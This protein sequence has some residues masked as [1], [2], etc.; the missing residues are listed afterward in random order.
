MSGN[1]HTP[2]PWRIV[3]S[4]MEYEIESDNVRDNADESQVFVLARDIGGRI[5]GDGFDDFSEREAN[6]SLISAS[7]DLL[8][9]AQRLVQ[10]DLDYP[11]NCY[12]GYA[13]LKALNEIIAD[14]KAAIAKATKPLN[15]A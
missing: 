8:A 12:D 15:P 11:V 9:I 3:K 6:V 5:H 1:K 13:G 14:A 10:W 4:F 7:P 2:G